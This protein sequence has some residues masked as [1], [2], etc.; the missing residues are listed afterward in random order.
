MLTS[1]GRCFRSLCLGVSAAAAMAALT[2][3]AADVTSARAE[4]P[5]AAPA[6][7][8]VKVD[9]PAA[10]PAAPPA[11]PAAPAAPS[12]SG[13][14]SS[15]APGAIEHPGTDAGPNAGAPSLGLH[16]TEI[17]RLNLAITF[18]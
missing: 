5:A 3:G 18:T 7:D 2:I 17:T 10:P 8:T 16:Q 9:A 11:P 1:F 13:I 15:A 12:T 6:P 14:P 4:E